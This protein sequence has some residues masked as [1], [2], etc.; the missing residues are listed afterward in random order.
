MGAKERLS[1]ATAKKGTIMS[2]EENERT[3][4][5]GFQNVQL[6]KSEKKQLEDWRKKMQDNPMPLI[7][8]LS[9]SGYLFSCKE[10][11]SGGYF[12]ATINGFYEHVEPDHKGWILSARSSDQLTAVWECLFWHFVISDKG[13][14]GIS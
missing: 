9:E 6:R 8:E 1:T 3:E 7:V 13:S 2:R 4:F 5:S 11:K 12:V 10:D 14:W